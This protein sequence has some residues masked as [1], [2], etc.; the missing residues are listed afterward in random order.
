MKCKNT[1]YR[2]LKLYFLIFFSPLK[3]KCNKCNLH[4]YRAL[5]FFPHSK[6]N[7]LQFTFLLC[8]LNE[9]VLHSGCTDN[10]HH[11]I[12]RQ[13]IGNSLRL[14]HNLWMEKVFPLDAT[15]R[16]QGNCTECCVAID[17]DIKSISLLRRLSNVSFIG[18]NEWRTF[19]NEKYFSS[20]FIKS[21]RN[22][23]KL[24]GLF[25]NFK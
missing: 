6:I 20:P 5:S 16:F 10:W 11:F 9:I 21:D 12:L 2:Q 18:E 19:M 1:F 3:N 8:I 24:W 7:I 25:I 14:S 23:K 22:W 13:L 17:D 4:F 15:D